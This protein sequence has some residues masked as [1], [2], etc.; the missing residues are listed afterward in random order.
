MSLWLDD[1]EL[2]PLSFGSRGFITHTGDVIGWSLL[3]AD[4]NEYHRLHGTTD[5]DF[6]TRWR[7][8]DA[9]SQPETDDPVA[10]HEAV[11]LAVWLERHADEVIPV[12]RGA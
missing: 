4:H 5:D 6:K 10:P 11:R 2:P 7:K 9:R 8:W 1:S 12:P 3:S